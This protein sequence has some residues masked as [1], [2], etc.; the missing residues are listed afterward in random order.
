[1]LEGGAGA[2]GG[3]MLGLDPWQQQALSQSL[4]LI[5]PALLAGAQNGQGMASLARIASYLA[6]IHSPRNKAA[7]Q[8]QQECERWSGMLDDE[9][10]A[11]TREPPSIV[12]RNS[13]AAPSVASSGQLVSAEAL[14]GP[15]LDAAL[16]F[17]HAVLTGGLDR[18]Q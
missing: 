18:K 6:S 10:G 8:E 3:G 7:F 2:S 14:S 16:D 1:M 9:I 17:S 13:G 11:R 5:G 12:R 4:M 15:E